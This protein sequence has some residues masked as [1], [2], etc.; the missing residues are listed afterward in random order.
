VRGIWPFNPLSWNTD[1][2][3]FL[4][5]AGGVG[6]GGGGGCMNGALLQCASMHKYAYCYFTFP[7]EDGYVDIKN[8]INVDGRKNN[9]N[10]SIK[11]QGHELKFIAF[12]LPLRTSD[13]LS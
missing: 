7:L 9:V 10:N 8:N 13:G 4:T 2:R 5:K 12:K 3:A 11:G 1:R 6:R